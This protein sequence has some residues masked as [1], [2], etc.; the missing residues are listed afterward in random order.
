M[1]TGK[2]Y[3][4]T[5]G[6]KGEFPSLQEYVDR[7]IYDPYKEKL[8]VE[9]SKYTITLKSPDWTVI[10]NTEEGSITVTGMIKKYYDIDRIYNI[11]N[12]FGNLFSIKNLN[13]YFHK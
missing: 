2:K 11:R 9:Q 1:Y 8:I 7:E 4:I 10:L 12:M 13:D 6:I 3:G 5:A